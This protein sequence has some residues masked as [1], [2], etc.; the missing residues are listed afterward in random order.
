M[1][2]LQSIRQQVT[3]K[4]GS[5]RQMMAALSLNERIEVWHEFVQLTPEQNQQVQDTAEAL[6]RLPKSAELFGKSATIV[7]SA[8]SAGGK[9][10]E[11]QSLLVDA[12]H[13]TGRSEGALIA[14]NLFQ[15]RTRLGNYDEAM[16]ILNSAIRGDAAAYGLHDTKKYPP[17]RMMGAGS[18]GCSFQCEN[19]AGGKPVALKALWDQSPAV[20][21][22]IFDEVKALPN[23]QHPAVLKPVDFGFSDPGNNAKPFFVFERI[24][25]AVNAESWLEKNGPLSMD[26][27][28]QVGTTLIEM[29]AHAHAAGLCHLN[30]NPGNVLLKR[31][32][33]NLEVKVTD[34]GLGK[35][36]TSLKGHVLKTPNQ[37]GNSAFG[38]KL[39]GMLDYLAPEQQGNLQYGTP[40]PMADYYAFGGTMFKLMTGQQP[41]D[42]TPDAMAANPEMYRIL[43]TLRREDPSTRTDSAQELHQWWHDPQILEDKQVAQRE[44]AKD[45][46]MVALGGVR[47][48]PEEAAAAKSKLPLILGIVAGVMLVAGAGAYFAFGTEKEG[49]TDKTKTAKK[50]KPAVTQ[51][52]MDRLEK[53][54]KGARGAVFNF[55]APNCQPLHDKG[56]KFDT[57]ITPVLMKKEKRGRIRT[58]RVFKLALVGSGSGGGKLDI[59]D[60]PGRLAK[61]HGDHTV[62]IDLWVR[63]FRANMFSRSHRLGVVKFSGKFLGYLDK[64]K[65]SSGVM[66]KNG[67]SLPRLRKSTDPGISALGRLNRGKIKGRVLTVSNIAFNRVGGTKKSRGIIGHWR[68]KMRN[69]KYAKDINDWAVGCKTTITEALGKLIEVKNKHKVHRRFSMKV[70]DWVG[71]FCKSLVTLNSSL[72]PYNASGV[73]TASGQLLKARADWNNNIHKPLVKVASSVETTIK[74]PRL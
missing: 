13:S 45:A 14:Y 71:G 18:L 38:K 29:L 23:V 49:T 65:Y 22:A 5:L 16:D 43:S 12:R 27:A 54:Y 56:F 59:F 21:E 73:A 26:Q 42:M 8:L 64:T 33:P 67:L 9:L 47:V 48:E 1:S 31:A 58:Y 25:G 7:A 72:K 3:A 19:A 44:A 39:N 60:C 2:D 57:K 63:N 24:P 50:V 69:E 41:R 61:I 53:W 32:G 68:A 55:L 66:F 36:V 51:N 4:V 17:L 20:G 70:Q 6:G 28:K 15:V 11:A 74:T 34:W 46:E 35:S 30:L 10:S 52:E 40:G 62:T 37:H